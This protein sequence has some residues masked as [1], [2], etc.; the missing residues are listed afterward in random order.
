MLL[1]LYNGA[2]GTSIQITDL[3]VDKSIMAQ[4]KRLN[5]SKSFNHY[6]PAN[7]M[8]KNI[9]TH[10]FSE[11]TIDRFEKLFALVNSKFD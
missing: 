11:E 5:E 8:A 3:D 2:F 9:G 6:S 10:R 4:L 7:Y 1:V